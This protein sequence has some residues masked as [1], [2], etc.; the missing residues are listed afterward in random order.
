MNKYQM[1]GSHMK[2]N[3]LGDAYD[4]LQRIMWDIH[5]AVRKYNKAAQK[6]WYQARIQ[7]WEK[8]KPP[9]RW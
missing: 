5:K 4:I 6:S 3:M 9:L 2:W 8:S 7:G 1:S